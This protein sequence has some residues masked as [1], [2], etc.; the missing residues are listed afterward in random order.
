[1]PENDFEKDDFD[2]FDE[3]DEDDEDDEPEDLP[4]FDI[5]EIRPLLDRERRDPECVISIDEKTVSTLSEIVSLANESLCPISIVD[6]LI[7][8][9]RI[10]AAVVVD[11][12]AEE[13]VF[14]DEVDF[15][16]GLFRAVLYLHKIYFEK[17]V[18]FS[19]AVFKDN[20]FFEDC[21]FFG[22]AAFFGAV[23]EKRAAFKSCRFEGN[24]T[25]DKAKFKG[26]TD[27]SESTFL[28]KATYSGTQFERAVDLRDAT[29]EQPPETTDSNI[30]EA[31]KTDAVEEPGTPETTPVEK[32]N[33]KPHA[34]F[35]PWR[36]MD[37]A[38]KK[39]MTRRKLLRGIFRFL[40]E[41][42]KE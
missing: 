26:E 21:T 42:E 29:F 41:D 19:H 23:F 13:S 34:A 20:V 5:S 35:N 27:F 1:M 12:S 39:T 14:A 18:D 24:A 37:E 6:C 2:D 38:S 7:K 3:D 25:F 22:V 36:K 10:R 11:L 40:P 9:T 32:P 28:E 33:Q 30:F 16:N 8:E 15:K 17:D 31:R 4:E